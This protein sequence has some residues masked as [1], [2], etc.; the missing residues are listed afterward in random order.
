MFVDIF[1]DWVRPALSILIDAGV[2]DLQDNANWQTPDRDLYLCL[3]DVGLGDVQ[4]RT[5]KIFLRYRPCQ[6]C[7]RFRGELMLAGGCACVPPA[8]F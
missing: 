2:C 1:P 8:F 6:F 5:G 3:S 4:P 7:A